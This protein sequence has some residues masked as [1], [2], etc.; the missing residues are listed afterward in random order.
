MEAKKTYLELL[1]EKDA[2]TLPLSEVSVHWHSIHILALARDL[3]ILSEK[4]ESKGEALAFS[5]QVGIL[6][7]LMKDVASNDAEYLSK[8]NRIYKE[9]S[10]IYTVKSYKSKIKRAID[11][12]TIVCMDMIALQ[13]K[14]RENHKKRKEKI[15]NE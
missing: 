1:L 4:L 5:Q 8:I 10:L 9:I 6:F 14:E 15:K 13:K 3:K 7:Q 11:D 2:T 12:A